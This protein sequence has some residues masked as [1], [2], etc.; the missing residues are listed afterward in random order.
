MN[1][2]K[3]TLLALA[4]VAL[5][6]PL[7]SHAGPLDKLTVPEER[8]AVEKCLTLIQARRLDKGT[9]KGAFRM[10]TNTGDAWI[11][12]Y[13]VLEAMLA[14]L[15]A[16]DDPKSDYAKWVGEYL[17]FYATDAL[18]QPQGVAH[19][20]DGPQNNP[21]YIA[22]AQRDYD[23]ID[24]YAGLFLL[25]SA[26]YYKLTGE[27]PPQVPEALTVSLQ[28]LNRVINDKAEVSRDGGKIWDFDNGADSN[29]L[30]IARATYP[31][32]QLM[33]AVEAHA[34]LREAIELF[35]KLDRPE[36]AQ[37]AQTLADGIAR[38]SKLFAPREDEPSYR[39]VIDNGNLR[40]YS[41]SDLY[42]GIMANLFALSYLTP[43]SKQEVTKAVAFINKRQPDDNVQHPKAPSE[44][45]LIAVTRIN[46][47][48]D[49]VK[50]RRKIVAANT[51]QF[52]S[53]TY[54]DRPAITI[55]ALLGSPTHFPIVP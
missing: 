9:A 22:I 20:Y 18:K 19:N 5:L 50:N 55:L 2:K 31:T 27:L 44:R 23:S 35:Q 54:I 1:L 43:Q 39:H 7:T 33:D 25:V 34:G 28:A 41:N 37:K 47:D 14:L 42:P 26:R 16:T 10:A 53:A 51:K 21:Q 36:D 3:L 8:Q 15:A 24:S 49:Y 30:P 12:H 17:T 29:G 6:W 13:F 38:G 45:W 4:L 52:G 48:S 40:D 11:E 32:H 46:P